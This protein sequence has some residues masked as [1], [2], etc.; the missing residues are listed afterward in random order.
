M[1]RRTYLLGLIGAALAVALLAELGDAL[2]AT[3]LPAKPPPPSPPPPEYWSRITIDG[4]SFG[5]VTVSG[6]P[7]RRPTPEPPPTLPDL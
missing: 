5:A 4:V 2:L 6:R 1:I 3:V 7:I